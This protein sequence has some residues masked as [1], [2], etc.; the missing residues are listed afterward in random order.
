M[1]DSEQVTANIAKTLERASH[2]GQSETSDSYGAL[3]DQIEE[4]EGKARE[5]FQSKIDFASLL[6]K[7]EKGQPLASSELKILELLI[8][9][10][11]EYYLKHETEFDH[12]TNE[13]KRILKEIEQ[14][15]SSPLDVDSLMHLRALCREAR[16][17]LP[18]IVF[19][20][21]QRERTSKFREATR[22]PL[23]SASSKILAEVVRQML[24]SDKM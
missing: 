11:A 7:L 8:V 21:D 5:A 22:G 17:V 16:R 14:L 6:P 15:Q 24:F 3:S 12:W 19:Y 13:L 20:L 2:C 4:L 1:A 23:D 18:D 9:G 10:D